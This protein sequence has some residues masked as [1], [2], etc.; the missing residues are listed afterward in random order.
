MRRWS[1]RGS[2]C[3]AVCALIV[4][5]PEARAQAY[6]H[7]VVRDASTGA[8]L[9]DALVRIEG[10]DT[11]ELR[12]TVTGAWRTGPLRSGAYRLRVRAIG[13]A[14]QAVSVRF[15]DGE[16]ALRTTRL[17]PSVLTLD[18]LVVTAAR[19]V[20]R[21]RDAV[22]TVEVVS[23]SDL[24]R[25]GASDL[26]SVLLEQTGIDLHAGRP[27][28]AG[29]MLQGLGSERV[30]V[31][32]D[33]QPVS[34]RI[35]GVFDVSRIPLAMV[36]RVEIVKGA[37]ST[38]YG[39]EAM[40]GVVNVITRAPPARA[41]DA[42]LAMTAGTHGRRDGAARLAMGVGAIASSL[43]VTRRAVRATPGIGLAAG[44]LAARL[45]GAAKLRWAPDA[46]RSIEASLLALDERQR[47]RAGTFY[48]FGDNTQVSARLSGVFSAGAHRFA[49]GLSSSVYDHVLRASVAPLPIAGDT[50]QRQMQ[51][52]QQVELLYAGRVSHA[53]AIDAGTQ[54]RVEAIETARVPGGR[55]SITSIE[56][57]VQ[58][59]YAP[60]ER[61]TL[62][63]GARVS[64]SAQWG[65]HVTPRVALRAKLSERLTLRASAG[66]AFRAPD[67]KELFLSFQ[68]ASA[69]YAVQGNAA[70]RPERSRNLMLG[71]E[72]ATVSGYVR[73]Q[74]FHNRF[75]D[76]IDTRPINAPNEPSVYR[77]ANV[78]DGT[79]SGVEVE[80]GAN[81]TE[82]GSLRV[83]GSLSLL[84]ARDAATGRALLARPAVG[85][86]LLVGGR[87]PFDVRAN[88]SAL[89]TGRTPMQRA[90]D[91]GRVT[92][93]RDSFLRTDVRLAHA[94]GNDGLE[95]VIGVDNLFDRRPAQWAGFTGRQLYSS[96]SWTLTRSLDP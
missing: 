27:A 20:E 92:A 74:S 23:R 40:G 15:D 1:P 49:P 78:D 52:V 62:L 61:L 19:R 59:S 37:Q 42:A 89:Y 94:I 80:A 8:L 45:D 58:V 18:Q 93:W 6:G 12:T 84:A 83:E 79:T 39:S 32:L 34:G 2:W 95:A 47:W 65:T 56:P 77:Y 38:L 90:A 64:H 87:L 16:N 29:V 81:F 14:A 96:L 9:P 53:V 30:L 66:D 50:G 60:T 33:G 25:T 4:A 17:E 85:A 24:E 26:A 22:T 28:G 72:L 88:A 69:G 46:A 75:R 67:F 76:F 48:N 63:P 11:L 86:R 31:L 68:N 13:Y 44:S 57:Y 51:R 3:L 70:L 36:E 35:A 41:L 55:R 10:I 7:G 82:R 5:A 91:T 54:V 71:L 43:D 21:L 73:A